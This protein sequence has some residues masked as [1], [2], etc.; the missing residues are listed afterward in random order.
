MV[1]YR[2]RAIYSRAGAYVYL[3]HTGFVMGVTCLL[4]FVIVIYGGGHG[5]LG[6]N[7]NTVYA[8]CEAIY[9]ARS[10]VFAILT[11]ENLLIAWEL[12]SLDRS[13]FS[14]CVLHSPVTLPCS[15]LLIATFAL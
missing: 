14:L 4:S 12:K 2:I 13:M 6:E 1:S 9:G 11:F 15:F 3:L 10:T 8:G 5:D 7:C